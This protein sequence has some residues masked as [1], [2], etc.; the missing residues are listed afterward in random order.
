MCPKRKE[1]KM[2]PRQDRDDQQ[3]DDKFIRGYE[4]LTEGYTPDDE[5]AALPDPPQGGS[6]EKGD[7]QSNDD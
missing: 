3:R 7:G 2:P 1:H 6:G 4:P 5:Q